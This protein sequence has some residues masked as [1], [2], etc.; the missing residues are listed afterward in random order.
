MQTAGYH[1]RCCSDSSQLQARAL[2]GM[3]RVTHPFQSVPNMELHRFM[4]L[5]Y[6]YIALIYA[7]FRRLW[8]TRQE[9]FDSSPTVQT[10]RVESSALSIYIYA[11][12]TTLC[13]LLCLCQALVTFGFREAALGLWRWAKLHKGPSPNSSQIREPSPVPLVF[14]QGRV[15]FLKAPHLYTTSPNVVCFTRSLAQPSNLSS[16]ITCSG[17]SNSIHAQQRCTLE[18]KSQLSWC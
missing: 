7:S 6:S 13:F 18:S 2:R 12:R 10:T 11:F 9:I 16:T 1:Q 15:C 3:N 14:H 5:V 8:Q 4:D 17:S